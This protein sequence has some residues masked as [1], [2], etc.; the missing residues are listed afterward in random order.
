MEVLRVP[1]QVVQ[2]LCVLNCRCLTPLLLIYF[3]NTDVTILL[4][5]KHLATVRSLT[6]LAVAILTVDGKQEREKVY[7]DDGRNL[8]FCQ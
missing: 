7:H 1:K 3:L 6:S 5:S 8:G 2:E 4:V